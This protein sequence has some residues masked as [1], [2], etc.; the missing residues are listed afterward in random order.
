METVT[1]T[2]RDRS[3]RLHPENSKIHIVTTR[4]PVETDFDTQELL[5]VARPTLITSASHS[6]AVA[7]DCTRS[8]WGWKHDF[9]PALLRFMGKDLNWTL[10]VS[11]CD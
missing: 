5:C 4:K 11:G 2:R 6:T 10:V 8:H 7:P 1:E 3:Y 9:S